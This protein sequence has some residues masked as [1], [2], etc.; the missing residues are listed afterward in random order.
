[1]TKRDLKTS[2]SVNDGDLIVLGGLAENKDSDSRDGPSFLPHFLQT[3][4][5][6]QSQSEIFLVLQV[7]RI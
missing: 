7:K 3:T 4:G 1:L 6:D 2:I 5:K